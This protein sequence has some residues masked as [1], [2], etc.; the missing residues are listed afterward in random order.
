MN[1]VS[2]EPWQELINSIYLVSVSCF[3]LFLPLGEYFRWSG[4]VRQKH[5]NTSLSLLL[6]LIGLAAVASYCLG[7]WISHA[8]ITG[9]GIT[10]GFGEVSNAWPWSDA[11]AP[12]LGQ[13]GA[14][15]ALLHWFVFFLTSAFVA[16]LV[17]GPLLERSKG[18][19]ILLLGIVAAGVFYP[20]ASAWLWSPRSW[21]VKLVGFH[22]AFGAASIHTL[23]GGFALG[24]L[25]CLKSRIA[26][27]DVES[28]ADLHASSNALDGRFRRNP[29]NIRTSGP[30]ALNAFFGFHC[31]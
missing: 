7:W 20:I 13:S 25:V 4:L 11:M 29:Y 28:T 27:H 16:L 14:S 30:V 24:A 10:G 5:R 17:A 12:H 22:D 9:P 18:G 8:F 3:M 19:A 15:A 2:A 21:M 23:A 1:A 31:K 26:V 6:C